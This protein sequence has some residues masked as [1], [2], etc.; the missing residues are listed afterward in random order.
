MNTEKVWETICHKEDLIKN[1][2]IC[3][4]LK[5]DQQIAIFL[6]QDDCV[7]TISNWDPA[8]KANVLYRGLIGDKQGELYVA[9]PL[10]KERYSLVTGK[11]F[12]NDQLTVTSYE[13]RIENS[14]VQVY[15]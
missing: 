12:D 7:F 3:A 11:C 10:Y 15:V 9:S 1:S 6:T 2:G 13:T 8:G 4:L 5:N 14:N